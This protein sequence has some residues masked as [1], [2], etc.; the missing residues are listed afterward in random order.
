MKHYRKRDLIVDIAASMC[1]GLATVVGL[2]MLFYVGAIL[3]PV[4]VIFA[5]GWLILQSIKFYNKKKR[6][7]FRR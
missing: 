5:L 6:R 2:C 3:L 1:I 4:F 7:G